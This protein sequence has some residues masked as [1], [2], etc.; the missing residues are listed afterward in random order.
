MIRL[1]A[2]LFQATRRW[3]YEWT[4]VL[5][6][7]LVWFVCQLLVLPGPPATAVLY[8][9]MRQSS[10]NQWWNGRD[11]CQAAKTLFWPAWQWALVNGLVVGLALFNLLVYW[12]VPGAW[13]MVLRFIWLLVLTI[14]LGLNLVYWPFWLAQTDKSLRNTYA[15]CGRFLLL[16]PLSGL[17]LTAVSALALF[18]SSLTIL[19]FVLGSMAYVALVG[20]TAVQHSLMMRDT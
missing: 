11:A 4:A 15:N 19:P 17:G 16:N 8:A 14:W 10:D 7:A 5:P 13:W 12:D 18:V 1:T 20:V 2:V 3:W 9:L 6:L